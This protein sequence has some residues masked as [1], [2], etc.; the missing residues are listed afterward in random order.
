M[1]VRSACRY[2]SFV[3][4]HPAPPSQRVQLVDTTMMMPIATMNMRI[5]HV[6]SNTLFQSIPELVMAQFHFLLGSHPANH[7]PGGEELTNHFLC[8]QPGLCGRCGRPLCRPVPNVQ[9]KR[10]RSGAHHRIIVEARPI[11]FYMPA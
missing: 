6:N 4:C 5:R 7:R 10:A 2:A 1:G 8:A 9:S 3:V 11:W